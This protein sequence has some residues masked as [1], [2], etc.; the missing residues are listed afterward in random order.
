MHEKFLAYIWRSKRFNLDNLTTTQ[1]EPLEILHTGELNTHSGP[2]FGNARIKVGDTLWAGNVEIHVKASDW[3]RHKHTID[4]AYDNTILHVIHEA[5]LPI[6]NT[7]GAEIPALVL[8]G[9]YSDNLYAKFIALESNQKPIPCAAQIGEVPPVVWHSWLDRLL[10]QR[11]EQKTEIIQQQITYAQNNWDEAFYHALGRNFGQKVNAQ[12]FEALAKSLPM[13]ILAK[14]KSQLFQIEALLFGQAGMLEQQYTDAHPE[15]L[16]KEYQYLKHKYSLQPLD[17]VQ[18]KYFRMRPAGF[19]T[20]RI[21][22]FAALVYHS[23]HLFSK[24]MEAESVKTL[25]H[26]FKCE[27]SAYWRTH[28]RFDT[29][30]QKAT[31]KPITKDQVHLIIYNTILPFWF[32]YG[33]AR[34]LPDLQK[35][36]LDFYEALPAEAN[37]IISDWEEVGKKAQTAGQSQALIELRT[38]FCDKKRCTHCAVGVQI[39]KV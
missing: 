31:A 15:S 29:E 26:L 4:R 37:Q 1:G 25:E 12:P 19:P 35:K 3:H 23:S 39:L 21:A 24:V 7:L 17:A 28:Y 9:K 33:K 32:L 16:R 20:I 34:Q 36:A 13:Q 30:T 18:W 22:Q 8:A 6:T 14:H 38:Q 5:D 11:L 27:V 10:V 2:D